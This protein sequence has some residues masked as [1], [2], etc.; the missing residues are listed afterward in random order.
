MT[1]LLR[2]SN[3]ALW[4]ESKLPSEIPLTGIP[5]WRNDLVA[6]DAFDECNNQHWA[7]F[8]PILDLVGPFY[9]EAVTECAVIEIGLLGFKM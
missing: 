2:V 7:E 5:M 6:Q 8:Q 1:S 9:D 4:I 3:L